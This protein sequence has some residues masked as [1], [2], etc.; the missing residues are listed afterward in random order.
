MNDTIAAIATPPGVGA[1]AIVRLSGPKA[2]AIASR[3]FHS[4]QPLAHR[5]A[6]YGEI[7]DESENTIDKGLALLW[8]APHS[9][10]GEESVEFHT[11]GSPVVAREVL[12]A[13]LACGARLAQ[14]GEFTQ[15]AF[16]NGKIDLHEASAV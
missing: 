9:Y 7:R 16:L 1:I 13:L 2:R 5:T 8:E 11:H 6:I 12:R 10:T 15:R 3:L 4:Q 14:P